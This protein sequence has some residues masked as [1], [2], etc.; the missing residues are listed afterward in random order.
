MQKLYETYE[1]ASLTDA[2]DP[3][4]HNPLPELGFIIGKMPLTVELSA[5]GT[6]LNAEKSPNND[7]EEILVPCTLESG[8]AR[9]NPVAP[10]PLFD[11]VKNL[12]NTKQ[13]P[14]LKAWCEELDTPDAVKVVYS[15]L[16]K[17]TLRTDLE[18]ALKPKK[19]KLNEKDGVRFVVSSASPPE[20]WRN[21]AVLD[22]WK[23]YFQKHCLSTATEELCYVLG[24]R[25]PCIPKHPNAVSTCIMI[26]MS[27]EKCAKNCDGRFLG[28]PEQALS[29]SGEVSLKAHSALK[30]LNNRQGWH[31]DSTTFFLAWD[32]GV[33]MLPE[34][35][36]YD[37]AD[38]PADEFDEP[39]TSARLADTWVPLGKALA[40]GSAGYE[41]KQ[42]Q[43]LSVK[44]QE[45]LSDVV[46]LFLES[47]TGKGR[48]SVAYEQEL[49]AHDYIDNLNYWYSTCRWPFSRGG[50]MA[51]LGR[52]PLP[53]EICNLLYSDGNEKLKKQ[54]IRRLISCITARRAIPADIVRAAFHKAITP[55]AFKANNAWDERGWNQAVGIAC[56]LTRKQ[57]EQEAHSMVLDEEQTDRNYLYGRLLAVADVV[58]SRALFVSDSNWRQTNAVRYMQ[59]FQQRPLET[60]MK[61]YTTYLPPYLNRLRGKG[62]SCT[63]LILTIIAKF[64]PGDMNNDSL[65][66]LF[67][68]GYSLQKLALTPKS[69]KNDVADQNNNQNDE[70]GESNNGDEHEESNE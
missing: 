28:R 30:W 4:G 66:G 29:I 65:N 36:T 63:N 59:R 35:N 12:E 50:K 33:S 13:L 67:L 39:E 16:Q 58:E 32:T 64:L 1:S 51:V 19:V 11:E 31:I 23:T 47:P 61:L 2:V 18:S 24:K 25:L 22:S 60:W 57:Y 53:E 70:G 41:G 8:V 55:L 52:T 42:L 38:D 15:Y 5:D 56:A 43:E 10:H 20:L 54:L 14:I 45:A 46:I 40:A 34:I 6:F 27:I 44:S 26:P 21:R 48:V 69:K 62:V 17:G 68:E 7:T 49:H 37:P 3:Y 9:A